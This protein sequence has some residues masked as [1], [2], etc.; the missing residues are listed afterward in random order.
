MSKG[1]SFTLGANYMGCVRRSDRTQKWNVDVVAL[2]A[3]GRKTIAEL[4]VCPTEEEAQ[5]LVGD[6]FAKR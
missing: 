1:F 4:D 3:A 5:K 2:F 6:W